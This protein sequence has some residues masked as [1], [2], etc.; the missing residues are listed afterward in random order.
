MK[1]LIYYILIFWNISLIFGQNFEPP[2]EKNNI[3]DDAEFG[4]SQA[5]IN[6]A[7]QDDIEKLFKRL[8]FLE[9]HDKQKYEALVKLMRKTE[10]DLIGLNRDLTASQCGQLLLKNDFTRASNMLKR[11]YTYNYDEVVYFAYAQNISNFNKI[12]D[13][14]KMLHNEKQALILYQELFKLAKS[15]ASI[16]DLV[17]M[18]ENINRHYALLNNWSEFRKQVLDLLL[19]KVVHFDQEH[20]YSLIID[21]V[22]KLYYR[23]DLNSLIK[24]VHGHT[25]KHLRIKGYAAIYDKMVQDGN[26]QS[27]SLFYL[28][29]MY[30]MTKDDIID[31]SVN[32]KRKLNGLINKL[33]ECI[34]NAALMQQV[35]IKNVDSGNYLKVSDQ[36][37]ESKWEL[38]IS[39]GET[40]YRRTK[41]RFDVMQDGSYATIKNLFLN[42]N[43]EDIGIK[44]FWLVVLRLTYHAWTIHSVGDHCFI[45]LY[46]NDDYFFLA[47]Y[48]GRPS[49][50]VVYSTW[51]IES[52]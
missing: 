41:W 14:A 35:C 17:N 51:D 38:V 31:D 1:K 10:N 21:V 49:I 8:D 15:D 50:T 23:L 26:L 48:E 33:P 3:D 28:A 25:N 24:F 20:A 40:S 11:V 12:I 32:I 9:K 29:T 18:V 52:C 19:S 42:I 16:D 7:T 45:K 46:G 27:Q 44:S 6:S 13:F 34:K 4:I 2:T 36:N 5:D 37:K 47:D 39:H 22:K 43:I 30:R